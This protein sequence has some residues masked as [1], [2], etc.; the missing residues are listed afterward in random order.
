MIIIEADAKTHFDLGFQIGQKLLE[1]YGSGL[2]AN[3]PENLSWQ[4]MI[5]ASKPYLEITE[6]YFP[7]YIEELKGI[8]YG[9]EI[10][11]DLL[12]ANISET[13]ITK[14]YS[15]KCTSFF[16]KN[17]KGFT[18]GHN[19]DG[20]SSPEED[21]L[22]IQK[23]TLNGFTVLETNYVFNLGGVSASINS[24]GLIQTINTLHHK[25][26]QQGVPRDIIARAISDSKNFQE[27]KDII[28]KI[29]RSY[30]YNHN[31]LQHGK[32]LNIETSSKNADYFE[33]K[34]NYV[35]TNHYT[36]ALKPFQHNHTHYKHSTT[37]RRYED[38]LNKVDTINNSSE[39]KKALSDSVCLCNENTVGSIIFDL[40]NKKAFFATDRPNPDT[41]WIEMELD[42]IK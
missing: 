12:W 20:G 18:V 5:E 2:F 38:A 19:E 34:E 16:A 3:K 1:A 41:R 22:Y 6:R 32:I 25:D 24:S 28:N 17:K 42:F 15:D 33:T 31:L 37:Y 8:S 14:D 4:E 40:P 26:F 36:R 30:G 29:P 39:M 9:S 7:Q 21:L 23:R 27:A 35:H 11:F 10:S 13:A